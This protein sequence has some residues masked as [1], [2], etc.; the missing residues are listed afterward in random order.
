MELGKRLDI[1]RPF[2][3]FF[4]VYYIRKGR[5]LPTSGGFLCVPIPMHACST[6]IPSTTKVIN[7]LRRN[8]FDR[9]EDMQTALTCRHFLTHGRRGW[10][11]ACFFFYFT[12]T[13]HIS[14]ILECF[15]WQL[16]TLPAHACTVKAMPAIRKNN[17]TCG[18]RGG[19]YTIVR[20]PVL[21]I[22]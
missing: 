6:P 18:K 9:G 12:C 14:S 2:I 21:H 15:L 7:G 3:S 4:P 17:N 16:F 5:V 1:A 22:C 11:H 10:L 20:R 19:K 13:L 8:A